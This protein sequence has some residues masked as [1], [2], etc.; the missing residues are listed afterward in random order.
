NATL[1]M[2]GGEITGNTI[3]LDAI[4]NG[5]GG[6]VCLSS[7]TFTM[8]GGTISNNTVEW[9]AGDDSYYHSICGAGVYA[10]GGT[11]TLDGGTIEQ[12]TLTYP[13]SES[14]KYNAC[15]AGVYVAEY[16]TFKMTSGKI[17]NNKITNAKKHQYSAGLYLEVAEKSD[18]ASML[19][20]GSITGNTC[21]I[22]GGE[23][24]SVGSNW[25]I[26]D[27]NGHVYSDLSTY[28]GRIYWHW[29][30]AE[31]VT[32][33]STIPTEHL[34]NRNR[35]TMISSKSYILDIVP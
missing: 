20:G 9:S 25:Y 33:V 24:D 34:A 27:L 14:D 28:D 29:G 12:N 19:I 13:S 31:D 10:T 30:Q 23:Q 18:A 2:S 17:T 5:S 15:G 4:S 16:C 26:A 3:T 1:I 7:G 11:F 32:D 22:P 8:S 21:K 6:G 35:D